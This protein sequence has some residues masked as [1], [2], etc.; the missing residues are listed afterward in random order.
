MMNTLLFCWCLCLVIS[1]YYV[2][3]IQVT[4]KEDLEFQTKPN[5]T[6]KTPIKTIYVVHNLLSIFFS[7]CISHYVYY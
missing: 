7:K 1:H 2:H 4:L 3:G 6:N 5:L